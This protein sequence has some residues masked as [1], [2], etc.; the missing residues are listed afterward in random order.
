MSQREILKALEDNSDWTTTTELVELIPFLSRESIN[1]SLRR[2]IKG[3]YIEYK[4]CT[5]LT[6]GYKYKAKIDD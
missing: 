2:L 4:K 5:E 1:E 6:H 3:K